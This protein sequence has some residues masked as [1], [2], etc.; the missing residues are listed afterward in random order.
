MLIDNATITNEY[1]RLTSRELAEKYGKTHAA[2]R[3]YLHREG[4]K[5]PVNLERDRKWRTIQ[6]LRIRLG[7][8]VGAI[9]EQMECSRGM[10]KRALGSLKRSYVQLA[11]WTKSVLDSMLV[12]VRKAAKQ[13]KEQVHEVAVNQLSLFA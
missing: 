5:A 7:W 4:I 10:V 11:M 8:T 12:E 3:A 2:M 6:K 9:A 13:H 1:Q